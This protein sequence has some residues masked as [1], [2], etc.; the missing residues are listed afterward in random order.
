MTQLEVEI[1]GQ[2]SRHLELMREELTRPSTLYQQSLSITREGD[3]Y[4]V[5]MGSN[6]MD[7]VCGHGESLAKALM[8]FDQNFY[9]SITK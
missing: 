7:G 8:D 2:H 3:K 1:V 5:L 6:L 9:K 4:S